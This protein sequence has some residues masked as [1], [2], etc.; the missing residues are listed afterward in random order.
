MGPAAEWLIWPIPALISPFA[1]VF[2]PVETLP[3]WMRVVS[4]VLPPSYVFEGVRA[5]VQGR[6][7][8]TWP[9]LAATAL[10]VLYLSAACWAFARTYR[11][12]VRTGLIARYSAETLS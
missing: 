7:V 9:L 11:R 10:A 12:V 1:G 3:E 2:Y 8:S 6:T 4:F 5:I